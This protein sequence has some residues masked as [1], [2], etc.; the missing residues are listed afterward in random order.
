MILGKGISSAIGVMV[1]LLPFSSRA[2]DGQMKRGEALYQ[3]KCLMCHQVSGQGVSPVFPPLAGS[4]WLQEDRVRTIRA[5]CEGL[6]GPIKVNG[7]MYNNAMPVQIMDDPQVAD[8]LT[9]V[10]QSWGNSMVAFAPAEVAEARKKSL[11]PTYDKLLAANAYQ[12]L[13]KAPDGWS[14]R[15]VARLPEISVRLASRGPGSPVYVLAQSAGIYQLDIAANSV[16]QVVRPADYGL[17]ELAEFGATGMT[18]DEEGRIWVVTNERVGN[19]GDD[20]MWMNHVVIWRCDTVDGR[21]GKPRRW[22]STKYPFSGGPYNHGVSHMAFGPDGMLYIN[23]GARTDGGELGK[24]P[25]FHPGGETDI[26]ACI[27]RMDPKA[28]RPEIEVFARGLRNAY[29]FAWDDQKRLFAVSN[30]PDANPC[31]EMDFIQPGKHYGFPYQFG[32]SPATKGSPYPHT[33]EA[34][35]NLEFTMP[36]ANLGP[37]AGGKADAPCYTFEPHSSPGGIIWCGADFPPLLRDSFLITR[38][39]NLIDCPEDVG[40]DLLS[41]KM[42]RKPDG[43]WQTRVNTVLAP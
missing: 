36:V 4:D 20:S 9:Y 33:P 22:F 31:E 6:S 29:G 25:K 38:F 40:F 3:Q 23:S 13:P 2:D 41:A 16:S 14:L 26:T 27:W 37:A 11:Y 15:E 12:P 10:G 17:G 32:N 42:E 18:V 19:Y 7:A 21:P 30:G 43:T 39:G 1:W 5:L 35:A 24:P 8:V 34:P 28:E